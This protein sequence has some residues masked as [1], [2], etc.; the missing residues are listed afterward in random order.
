MDIS[1]I[2]VSALQ[3]GKKMMSKKTLLVWLMFALL[4][5]ACGSSPPDS[6]PLVYLVKDGSL[7][8]GFQGSYCWERNADETICVDM[9]EPYFDEVVNLPADTPIRF[10]FEE[11]LPDEVTISISKA[12]LS[13]SLFSE[14]V[15][16][17]EIVNWSAPVEPGEYI[18]SV[19]CRW[20]QG[21][22]SYLF[23]VVIE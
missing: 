19:G 2:C 12:V 6:P 13:T 10:Q 11:P 3:K 15:S 16:P 7:F 18:V 21:G 17:S 22:G 23:A 8:D 14:N 5:S 1:L 9:V 20:P 4:L